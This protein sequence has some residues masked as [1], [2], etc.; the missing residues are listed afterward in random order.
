MAD[1]DPRP[2]HVTVHESAAPEREAA[3]LLEALRARRLPG[4]LLYRSPA[5]AR[6]WLAYHQAYS[7]SRTDKA[8]GALYEQAFAAAAA[9]A[10]A[11][12]LHLLSLGCGGGQKDA[13]LLAAAGKA[14]G[15][16]FAA[17]SRYLPLDA[18]PALVLEAVG[19]VRTTFPGLPAQ[20]LVADLAALPHL[21][22]WLGGRIHGRGKHGGPPDA[23]SPSWLISCF[24][25]LPNF[26]AGPFCTWLRGLLRP[27]GRLLIS[28]NLC[29]RG[30]AADGPAILAQ[31][32][33]PPALRWY[34]G[35]LHELGCDP[36]AL[37][38]HVCARSLAGGD[39]AWQ[40]LVEAEALRGFTLRVSGEELSFGAGER[41][42]VFFSNRFTAPACRALL[43]GAGLKP[44]EEW[45]HPG[46]E[47]GIFYCGAGG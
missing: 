6:L 27:G 17:G 38:L 7:P 43:E 2:V 39:D 20:P 26:D 33:N 11:G 31:Y 45:L 41:I 9:D 1:H 19:R 16:A 40:V 14:G 42:E 4:A 10:R 44:L 18:S 34:A 24:G 23:G 29:P 12:S 47:E 3:A 37:R 21:E 28:A 13:A 25:M 30:M 5:Q 36:E 35:A 8:M 15:A 22:E 32:D 46:G